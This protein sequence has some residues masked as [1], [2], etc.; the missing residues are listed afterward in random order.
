MRILLI[1]KTGQVGRE[2]LSALPAVGDVVATDRAQLDLADFQ[3]IRRVTR[4]ARADVIVNA[5]AYTAVDRAESEPDLA[6]AV[7]A[8]APGAIA[9]ACKEVG[10]AL[11]HISTDYV[12]DGMAS[13]AYTESDQI[14][15]INVYGKTKA[16]GFT[17]RAFA[18]EA[19]FRANKAN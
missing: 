14:G 5:A 19:G 2:L 3:A 12:F 17:C 6:L 15:P 1:G 4:E 7:N 13:S 11:V 9:Q 18:D 16:A 8:D 10:A